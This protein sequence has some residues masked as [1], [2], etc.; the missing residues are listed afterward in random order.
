DGALIH[1]LTDPRFDHPKTY[2][3]QVEGVVLPEQ[4]SM[5]SGAIL[6]PELQLKPAR[7][8]V[9]A[10]P[11][12]PPRPTP[13]RGYHPTT[14]LKIVLREGKKHQVRRMTAAVGYPT[15]RLV[16]V[17]V[18]GLTLAGLSPGGWRA[19]AP[20]E[21]RRASGAEASPHG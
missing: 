11:S 10:D 14:W 9:V 6:L 15:L 17:A 5:W 19:V 13:V 7:I 21:I 12:L 16:R 4:A 2:L 20:E 18:G 1:R 8:E 3:A